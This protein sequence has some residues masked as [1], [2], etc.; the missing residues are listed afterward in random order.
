MVEN[1]LVE[2]SDNGIGIEEK[3]LP[4]LFERFYRVDRSRSRAEGGSGLG[5]AIVKH[6]IEAH[7]QTVNV[8]ST[9]GLGSTFSF[10]VKKS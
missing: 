8:R 9:Q 2:I 1:F 4:R 7:E 5:L 10:T 6:I 3:H